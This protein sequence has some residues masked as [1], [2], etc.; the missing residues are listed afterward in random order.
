M[1]P[2]QKKKKHFFMAKFG[3]EES[4]QFKRSPY[5]SLSLVGELF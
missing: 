2:C 1:A 5:E 4:E 3:A